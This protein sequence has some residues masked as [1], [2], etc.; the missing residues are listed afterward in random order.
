MIQAVLNNFEF[1]DGESLTYP[2][3]KITF[4]SGALGLYNCEV[5]ILDINIS[6]SAFK[7]N[8]IGA[9]LFA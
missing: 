9:E 4:S 6:P 3:T 7:N 8:P 1:D 2:P 5:I